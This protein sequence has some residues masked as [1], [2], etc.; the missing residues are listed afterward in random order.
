MNF[1]RTWNLGAIGLL[2]GTSLALFAP[3]AAMAQKTATGAAAPAAAEVMTEDE[4]SPA[5]WTST[6]RPAPA[7]TPPAT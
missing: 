4:S 6:S 5:S 1:K 3:G 7:R 2:A